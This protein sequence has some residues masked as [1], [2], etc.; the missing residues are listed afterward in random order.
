MDYELGYGTAPVFALDDVSDFV[1]APNVYCVDIHIHR[2]TRRS[3]I[4]LDVSKQA[5]VSEDLLNT[6][7]EVPPVFW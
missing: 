6:C 1:H 3:Q 4:N 2:A 5:D 7:L